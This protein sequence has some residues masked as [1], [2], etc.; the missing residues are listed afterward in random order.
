MLRRMKYETQVCPA[1]VTTLRSVNP[2]D[3]ETTARVARPRAPS[4]SREAPCVPLSGFAGVTRP[5]TT[6]R[7][8]CEK[9]TSAF[10]TLPEAENDWRGAT[11]FA[12]CKYLVSLIILA[13]EKAPPEHLP[14]FRPCSIRIFLL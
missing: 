6:L 4:K 11:T 13:N 10:P 1:G 3:G 9:K 8:R 2:S 12:I 14:S 7:P 5:R